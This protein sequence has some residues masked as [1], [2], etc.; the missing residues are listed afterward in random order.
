MI[1]FDQGEQLA[2]RTFVLSCELKNQWRFSSVILTLFGGPILSNR[3]LGKARSRRHSKQYTRY[4][5]Q[6]LT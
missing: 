1:S 6:I 3:D 2:G 4:V 5:V